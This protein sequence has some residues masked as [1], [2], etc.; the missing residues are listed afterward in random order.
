MKQVELFAEI[1][2]KT[3]KGAANSLRRQGYIPAVFYG[4]DSAARP[5]SLNRA[6]LK[7]KL[8]TA[9]GE[10][11]LFALTIK[12]NNESINKM[13][14]LKEVQTQPITHDILHTDF[15]EVLMDKE[16]TIR[17]PLAIKGRAKG[18]EQGGILQ[19]VTREIELECLPA[20]IPESIEVDVASLDIGE[21]LHIRDLD[22]SEKYRILDDP[23]LT[24][25]SLVPPETEE[26]AVPAEEVSGEPDV[27][28]G[29]GKAVE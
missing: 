19:T 2:E 4:K 26:K 1:R 9:R 23:E 13:A 7:R 20:D 12:D 5:L 24:L 18:I 22:L 14:I 10:N 17:V 15:Y 6:E 27:V 28:A 16:I 21:S 29:K 25:V 11:T 3:G 8:S